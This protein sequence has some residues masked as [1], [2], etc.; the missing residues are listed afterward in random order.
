MSD[1]KEEEAMVKLI[2]L[3]VVFIFIGLWWF[4]EYVINPNNNSDYYLIPHTEYI[5]RGINQN[6]VDYEYHFVID[7]IVSGR[8]YTAVGRYWLADGKE[9]DFEISGAKEF[10]FPVMEGIVGIAYI[11]GVESKKVHLRVH[12]NFQ[13]I[14][15]DE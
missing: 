8:T 7:H 2:G 15:V 6:D 5:V 10:E 9:T 11:W 3:I 12:S 13:I 4:Y 14:L 1:N